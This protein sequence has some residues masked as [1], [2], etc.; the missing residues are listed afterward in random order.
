MFIFFCFFSLFN[1]NIF[2]NSKLPD[3]FYN[4]LDESTR[5]VR[6]LSLREEQQEV[7][8]GLGDRGSE[9]N[10]SNSKCEG[11]IYFECLIKI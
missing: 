9:T 2:D 3:S 11:K 7:G 1:F 4:F 6:R 10:R 8:N 5:A